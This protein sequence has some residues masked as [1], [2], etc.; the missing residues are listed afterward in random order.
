MRK[1]VFVSVLVM[2][3]FSV[4][5]AQTTFWGTRGL[6]RTISAD[7]QG[8]GY[9]SLSVHGNYFQTSVSEQISGGTF[10]D[11]T[12][13]HSHAYLSGAFAPFDFVEISG[14][15]MGVLVS[16]NGIYGKD[17]PTKFGFGDSYLGLKGSYSP[18]W[19]FAAGGYGYMTFATGSA[20]LKDSMFTSQD[21]GA[22]AIGCVTFDLTDPK[23][24]LPLPFRLHLN[25]GYY[26]AQS[27]FSSDDEGD[28]LGYYLYRFGVE[29]PAGN[30]DLFCDVSTEQVDLEGV[31]FSENPFRITPGVRFYGP[32][33][34]FDLGVDIGVG[35]RGVE[36]VRHLDKMEWKIVGGFSFVTRIIR[37]QP[38]PIFAEVTGRVTD[39]DKGTPILTTVSTDDTTFPVPFVTADDGF[40]KILLSAGVH[41]VIFSA[42]GYETFTKSIT[43]ADSIGIPLDVTLKPLINYGMLTG[44]VSD[45]NTGEILSGTITFPDSEKEP[46]EIN[47]TTGVYKTQLP[48]GTYT[49][50]LKIDEYHEYT[51][52]VVI[53]KDEATQKDIA[54]RPVF[55]PTDGYVTGTITDDETGAALEAKVAISK[56]GFETVMSSPEDGSY[57]LT[58]PEGT[59]NLRI[60]KEGYIPTTQTVVVKVEETTVQEI[61]LKPLPKGWVTGK[62]TNTKDSQPLQA[63]IS[64]PG[65][66]IESVVADENGIFKLSTPPGTYTI[67][68]EYGDFLP[69][70]FPLV[71]EDDKTTVQ[72][73]EL[74]KPG[75]KITLTGIYFDFNKA[76]I[77]PESRSTLDHAIKILK[78]NPDI[79]VRIEGHTDSKGSDEYNMGL[80][81]RRADAVKAYLVR[82]GAVDAARIRA[83]GKGE[84]EP[85]ASN[86]TEE[87]RALN[88]RIE[89]IVEE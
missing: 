74:I 9:L 73:F 13:R 48:V 56:E 70:A 3:L 33:G 47:K 17:E 88:R 23:A 58:L 57:N 28:A 26:K 40:Y 54:L 31:D 85:I 8:K 21:G 51:D 80:S 4:I 83:V 16:D 61:S 86:D 63:K 30:F 38:V 79:Q 53:R 20:V 84:G 15:L 12:K 27:L 44:K 42:D 76:T 2:L 46:I 87:G 29:I 69:Q 43:V 22:G 82:E 49:I 10:D 35:D 39:V 81:Q 78:D 68:A 52:V 11:Y 6:F 89:F 65:S 1:V 66:D 77:K 37:E 50:E 67:K 19:W 41:N 5:H 36:T 64:F 45:I 60:E 71:V 7:N 75:E 62:V 18:I 25:M 34:A 32:G 72:N 59:Y 55:T 24:H 14:G